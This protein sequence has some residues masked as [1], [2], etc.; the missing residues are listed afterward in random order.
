MTLIAVFSTLRLRT[1]CTFSHEPPH[2]RIPVST[3]LLK[4]RKKEQLE[5]LHACMHACRCLRRSSVSNRSATALRFFPAL[6]CLLSSWSSLLTVS[7][8]LLQSR[9]FSRQRA[10]IFKKVSRGR[11]RLCGSSCR[12]RRLSV[13]TAYD[14]FIKAAV[15]AW[16][17][18]RPVFP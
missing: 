1:L 4:K 5:G 14:R 3:A 6:S 18:Q 13:S 9:C 2:I 12:W 15:R 10:E 7:L 17:G 16:I 8:C 11:W